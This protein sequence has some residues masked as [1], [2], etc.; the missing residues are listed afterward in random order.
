MSLVNVIN[1]GVPKLIEGSVEGEEVFF[2]V[3]LTNDV[4]TF[5]EDE[6][7]WIVVISSEEFIVSSST[8]DSVGAGSAM[9]GVVAFASF[10]EILVV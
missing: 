10:Q 8:I 1:L 3:E 4:V 2:E 6:G 9:E 5:G 7:V